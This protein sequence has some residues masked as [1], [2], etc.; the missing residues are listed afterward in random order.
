MNVIL[1]E[2]SCVPVTCEHVGSD[3]VRVS[4]ERGV[5][6]PGAHVGSIA[7]RA[8]QSGWRQR[9]RQQSSAGG[10]IV[11]RFG[12]HDRSSADD[13]TRR[14]QQCQIVV[15]SIHGCYPRANFSQWSGLQG[16]YVTVL[17]YRLFYSNLFIYRKVSCKF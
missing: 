2:C 5:A 11:C 15:A 1:Q 7:E 16:R 13:R 17:L 8:R 4:L 14:R 3:G 12:R 10:G 9:L 6:N